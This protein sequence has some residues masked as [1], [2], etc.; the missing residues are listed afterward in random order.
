MDI[1]WSFHFYEHLTIYLTHLTNLLCIKPKAK[2]EAFAMVSKPKLLLYVVISFQT[3]SWVVCLSYSFLLVFVSFVCF[4]LFVTFTSFH[5]LFLLSNFS[6]FALFR[7]KSYFQQ[8]VTTSDFGFSWMIKCFQNI[9]T[10]QG[11]DIFRW[12]FLTKNINLNHLKKFARIM[13]RNSV[14]TS[15]NILLTGLDKGWGGDF[16]GSRHISIN[17]SRSPPSFRVWKLKRQDGWRFIKL[18]VKPSW[19]ACF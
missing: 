10:L 7:F 11:G 1:N 18:P 17:T 19:Q 8:T 5:F 6:H 3:N 15:P 2:F 14:K 13:T 4:C 16:K 12:K 9:C